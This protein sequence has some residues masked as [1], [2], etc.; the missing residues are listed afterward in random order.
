MSE[1]LEI[2]A[3]LTKLA[4]M[5]EVEEEELFYLEEVSS[6]TIR[7]LRDQIADLLFDVEESGLTHLVGLSR[8]LPAPLVANVTQKVISPLLAARIAGNVEVEHAIAVTRRLP[9][10]YLADV[11]IDMDP[12]RASEVIGGMPEPTVVRVASELAERGEAVAMGRFASHLSNEMMAASFDVIDDAM[13]IEIAF[14]LEDK[15]QLA[16]AMELLPDERIAGI[17]EV[18][19]EQDMWP[20]A[21]DLV[22]HLNAAQH[23]RLANIA[24]QETDEVLESLIEAAHEEDLWDVVL[25]M[26]RAMEPENLAQVARLP[27]IYKKPIMN[28]LL[29]SASRNKLWPDVIRMA[30]AIDD[31]AP[32]IAAFS[33]ADA[34]AL[35]G[36]IDYASKKKNHAELRALLER[37]TP[38][39]RRQILRRAEQLELLAPD[40]PV[41]VLLA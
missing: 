23:T 18:A 40:S 4:R 28:E 7:L 37:M 8:M 31:L 16:A 34:E 14:V 12:R 38:A 24:A 15:S 32:I 20:Q 22:T 41:A 11:A 13:M 3:E 2:R 1:A 19:A 5:L 39:S 21:L 9:L 29:V 30:S 6:D 17:I 10:D 25:P 36:L 26:M 33:K 35:R 27:S